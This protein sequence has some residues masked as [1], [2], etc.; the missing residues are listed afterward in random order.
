MRA[1]HLLLALALASGSVHA[2]AVLKV[3]TKDTS[4]K[5]FPDEVYY[6][7]NGMMRIDSLDAQGNV[8]R[9]DI[10]RD[11][12][13]WEANTRDRTFSRIDQQSVGSAVGAENSKLQA[14]MANLPADQRA[15]MQA[16]VAQLGQRRTDTTFTDTGRSDQS[17]QYS[18]R[19][20]QEQRHGG[21]STEYCVVAASSLPDGGELASSMKTAF[22]TANKIIAGVPM[23][24]P[25]AEHLTRLEKMNGF[26]VRWRSLSSAGATEDEHV[27]T[28]AQSQNLPTDTFAIPQGFSEKP[29]GP[30][31][32]D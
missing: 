9:M 16:R 20:W 29:L 19:V 12:V 6:A 10:I 28:S 30:G 14:M 23:M 3:A 8:V 7:Q 1:N 21:A 24:A 22:A 4:G 15:M 31:S 2:G 17:A 32:G 27:L 13:I 5:T 25:R 18:C 11:G 26:P